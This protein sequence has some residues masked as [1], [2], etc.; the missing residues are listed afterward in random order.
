MKLVPFQPASDMRSTAM[1][2]CPTIGEL[3]RV[4][5]CSKRPKQDE[6]Y[7][8]NIVEFECSLNCKVIAP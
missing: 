2:E 4:E 8:P 7:Y 3:D 5:N 1:E 6:V